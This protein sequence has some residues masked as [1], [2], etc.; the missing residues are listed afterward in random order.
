MENPWKTLST[1][2]VYDNRWIQVT[3]SD[4]IN[5]SG[6]PG[7]YGKVHFKNLAV[8]V[9]PLD[10]QYN[11][12]LVGQYRYTLNSYEWELPEGGCPEGEEPIHTAIRELKEETG[13]TAA[14]IIP[15]MEMQLS[16]SVS[17]EI[18]YSFIARELSFSESEPEDTEQLE[19]RKVPF[20]EALRMAMDGEIK[21]ALS[22][23][24]ILKTHLLIVQGK[25]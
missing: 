23:A 16:N 25:L 22:V 15:I 13:I 14:Q 1:R 7:I 5:P 3:E 17:D 18:S 19:V 2:I 6:N 8:A 4:I 9:L 10:D 24:T 20:S 21:D 12:W 11:T